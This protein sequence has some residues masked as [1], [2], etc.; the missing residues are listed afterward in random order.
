MYIML[1]CMWQCLYPQDCILIWIYRTQINYITDSTFKTEPHSMGAN[2]FKTQ[3]AVQ[4]SSPFTLT[5]RSD[6][7]VK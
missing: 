1:V 3:D 4:Q 6:D 5:T 7:Q 2:T